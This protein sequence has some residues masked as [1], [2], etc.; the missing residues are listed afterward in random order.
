M[1]SFENVDVKNFKLGVGVRIDKTA[2]I[3]GDY[4]EIGDRSAIGAHTLIEGRY[5]KLG[6]ETWVGEYAQIGGGSAFSKYSRL[7]AGDFFHLGRFGIVNTARA[8]TIGDEVGLG[9]Q[10][11]IFTH[12][13]YLSE[14]DGFPVQFAP[15]TIGSRVW[16]PYAV[17]NP[18]VNIGSDVVVAAMSLV[19]KD[20][21]SGALAGGIPARVIRENAYPQPLSEQEAEALL[22]SLVE[23]ITESTPTGAVKSTSGFVCRVDEC[24]F[25]LKE[26][27]IA[28]RA[29]ALSEALKDELRRHGIRFRYFAGEDGVYMSW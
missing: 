25:D 21:P 15:V 4:V 18:G 3:R 14:I 10:T 28:G 6:R 9:V 29:S 13:A 16:L 12:G 11:C 20:I 17:V 27:T 26:R 23:N 8:V 24:T 5:V 19:N 7:E 1:Q 22:N 2:R